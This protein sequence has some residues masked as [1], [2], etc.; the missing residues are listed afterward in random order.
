MLLDPAA[1][2]IAACRTEPNQA[3]ISPER[4]WENLQ[5]PDR[6]CT[7][8]ERLLA[9]LLHG[10]PRG[11]VGGIG[12]TGQMHGVLYLDRGGRAASPLFTW[13]DAR[14]G[15][16]LDGGSSSAR[17][18]ERLTGRPVP[19]GFGL[20]THYHNMTRGLVPREA[21]GLCTVM[22]YLA[23]RLTA[24]GH[25]GRS[26]SGGHAGARAGYVR[27]AGAR[28]AAGTGPCTD[29]TN[30]AGLGVFDLERG[31]FDRDALDR[32]GI[33]AALLPPVVPSGT[34]IGRCRGIPVTVPLGDNQASFL[35]AV[36]EPL[37]A[38]HL[39]L[40]TG[41]QVSA[42][43][44]G[45]ERAAGLDGRPY[46]GGGFLLVGASIC[47]GRAYALLASFFRRCAMLFGGG[48]PELEEVYRVMEG[49]DLTGFPGGSPGGSPDEGP[50]VD[51][52]F[53]GTRTEPDRRGAVTGIT[54]HNFTPERLTA[55]FLEGIAGEM[56][57]FF[58]LM[59]GELRERV[60]HLVGSGN[61]LRMNRRLR[62]ALE[63]CFGLPLR[64]PRHTEEAAF[65]AALSAASG[66]GALPSF[67]EAGR[68]VSYR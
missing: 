18:L 21:A 46:P 41:G 15:L 63:R 58:Q 28:A 26:G 16:P 36:A 42:Y 24:G 9:G 62:Q 11:A 19:P 6:L 54:P 47:G 35:G 56:H 30:G 64:V 25:A 12:I 34:V 8:A 39:N 60:D 32:A 38:L 44:P 59:P 20:A 3:G 17:E 66:T 67:L 2:R 4:S 52:R 68:A 1:G 65:G 10:A 29:P 61:A 55:G 43:T 49:M 50:V 13:L 51:T 33:D 53:Q 5:D 45:L 14:A 31:D 27:E 22:D 23:L 48:V 7:Q 37:Q 40:G 57:G